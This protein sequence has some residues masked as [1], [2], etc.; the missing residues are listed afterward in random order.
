MDKVLKKLLIT[1]LFAFSVAFPL[2][3]RPP[4]V[5]AYTYQADETW[6]AY[7][8]YSTYWGMRIVAEMTP[9]AEYMWFTIPNSNY[10]LDEAGGID[11][12]I[13][14]TFQQPS[15]TMEFTLSELSGYRYGDTYYLTLSNILT[16]DVSDAY[17][18][19]I[20]VMQS[21]TSAPSQ[22]VEY[23][24]LNA[25]VYFNYP[26]ATLVK[27]YNNF[28][29]YETALF[30][31][32]PTPP[33]DPTPAAGFEFVGW[34][35]AD[36]R[37]YTFDYMTPD[38]L[39]TTSVGDSPSLNLYALYRSEL[40]EDLTPDAPVPDSAFEGLLTAF[41][42]WNDAGTTFLYVLLLIIAVFLLVWWKAPLWLY[43]VAGLGITAMFTF[44]G[45]LPIGVMV[46]MFML[47]AVIFLLSLKR[48]ASY[49]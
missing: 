2:A 33:A 31:T 21:W 42:L 15:T 39:T 26:S 22:F 3:Y 37:L 4:E 13:V 48:G 27:Y 43:L 38:L 6:D 23:W 32:Y 11:S 49:E 1:L 35:L 47:F 19:A 41:G 16:E 44:L 30:Y 40:A 25:G 18:V 14:F 7:N 36:G 29:V 8:F 10:N 45:Y 28:T 46:V 34:R 9:N 20:W 12:A 5:S 17:Q 24:N